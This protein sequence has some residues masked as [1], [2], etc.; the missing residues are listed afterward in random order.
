MI[1]VSFSNEYISYGQ[2]IKEGNEY[3]IETVQK[4]PLTHPFLPENINNPEFTESLTRAFQDI[5]SGLPKPDSYVALVLPSIWFDI[6]IQSTDA[7]LSEEDQEETLNWKVAKRLGTAF[8][9]KFVQ[10]YPIPSSD[11]AQDFLTVSYFKEIGKKLLTASQAVG[12]NINIIDIDLFS[13]AAAIERLEGIKANERWAVWLIDDQIHDLLV[14]DQG[15]FR[16]YCRFSFADIETYR[17]L[18]KSS[19]DD[20]S[21]KIVAE[22]NG[23]RTFEIESFSAVDRVYFYSHSVDSEF[24]NMLLTYDIEN[25]KTIDTFEKY[26]PEKLYEE[27]G[28]GIGAMCQFIELL[29]LMFRKMPKDPE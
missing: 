9:R 13:A 16:Q 3:I 6:S 11:T 21:E 17:I 19:A 5:L 7:G 22:L 8:D 18:H 25:L 10:Y 4:L 14:I 27:D 28:D 15:N 12:L 29:G 20:I 24:F 23:I 26:K 2:L 1:C